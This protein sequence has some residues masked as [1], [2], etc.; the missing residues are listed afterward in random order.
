MSDNQLWQKQA[1]EIRYSEKAIRFF[2][3]IYF[4]HLLGLS[5]EVLK[6]RAIKDHQIICSDL[7]P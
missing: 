3:L 5:K 1:E 6:H 4:Y 7:L 2:L